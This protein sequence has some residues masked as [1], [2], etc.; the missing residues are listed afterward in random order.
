MQ[1]LLK[2]LVT[3]ALEPSLLLLQN[4]AGAIH[5]FDMESL[6]YKGG[7]QVT[8]DW[9]YLSGVNVLDDGQ[10][11]LFNT[12]QNGQLGQAWLD[13]PTG[14]VCQ[15]SQQSRLVAKVP[16]GQL[17]FENT[18]YMTSAGNDRTWQDRLL[19]LEVWNA[20]P[21]QRVQAIPLPENNVI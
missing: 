5:S 17:I 12:Y 1:S 15:V 19:R 3:Q 10:V 11:L 4:G 8:A 7:W 18:S 13:T 14:S 16:N 6:A 9:A 2:S 21:L 20:R